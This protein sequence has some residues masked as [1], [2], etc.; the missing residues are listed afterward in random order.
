MCGGG[1][2]VVMEVGVLV[3]LLLL[4]TM[5]AYRAD[6]FTTLFTF[7]YVHTSRTRILILSWHKVVLV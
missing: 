7:F 2:V 6:N 5:K 1:L 3:G 4:N